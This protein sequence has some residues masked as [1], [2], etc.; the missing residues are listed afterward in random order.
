MLI[1]GIKEQDVNLHTYVYLIFHI[2][3]RKA[4]EQINDGG[5]S[6]CL[7][8]EECKE[9]HIYHPAQNSSSVE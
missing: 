4:F 6:G 9:N 2:E 1:N 3:S 5:E 8:V 7:Y